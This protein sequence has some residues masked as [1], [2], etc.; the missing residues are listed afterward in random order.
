[1]IRECRES[2]WPAVCEMVAQDRP[3]LSAGLILSRLSANSVV[4]EV[5][6]LIQGVAA[7]TAKRVSPTGTKVSAWVYTAPPSR[8]RG[9]GGALWRRLWPDIVADPPQF[10]ATSYRSDTGDAAGFFAR[11][12]FRHL[13]SSDCLGYRGKAIDYAPGL[14]PEPYREQHFWDFIS[15]ANEAFLQLRQDN[16]I[17][18]HLCYPPG[19]DESA[20]RH[21][22]MLFR[23]GVF[24]FRNP[25]GATVGYL[26]VEGPAID[27]I[28]VA[29]GF[30]GQGYGS[31]IMKYAINLILKHGHSTVTL[32]VAQS[33]Q[34]AKRLYDALGFTL[35]ESV[36]EARMYDIPSTALPTK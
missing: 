34:R 36:D 11:R 12:G 30:T 22:L 10:M 5:G 4:F 18:P 14:K 19:F 3:S 28:A 20:A 23:E 15:L 17:L 29:P 24:I 35:L 7:R 26:W 21:R 2:D 25:V 1:M 33:N 31:E 27:A 8:H 6:G 32:E 16:G 9:I 13:V